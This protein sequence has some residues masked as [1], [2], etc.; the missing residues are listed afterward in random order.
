MTTWLVILLLAVMLSPLAWLMPSNRQR[1]KMALRLEAR[2]LGLA[3]QLARQDWPHWLES[4]PP[5]S[6]A[7]FHCPRRRGREAWC[8][9][10]N[11]P[12]QWLNQWREPCADDELLDALR[13]LPGM[14][15]RWRRPPSSLPCIGASAAIA[16]TSGASPSFSASARLRRRAEV[17]WLRAAYSAATFSRPSMIRSA[18]L[19]TRNGTLFWL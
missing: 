11:T 4:A 9:W 15:T 5:T 1:G 12:G 16:P 3:M 17:H 13:S 2:R 19:L 8:Y 18:F 7:Q 6:C 14:S 10:Q